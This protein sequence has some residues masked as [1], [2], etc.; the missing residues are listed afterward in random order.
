MA[1]RAKKIFSYF[2]KGKHPFEDEGKLIFYPPHLIL[3]FDHKSQR[4]RGGQEDYYLP[5]C[6]RPCFPGLY[7]LD[8]L[9]AKINIILLFPL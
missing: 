5:P 6:V 4:G 2:L 8:I 7:M 1:L 3:T 9:R